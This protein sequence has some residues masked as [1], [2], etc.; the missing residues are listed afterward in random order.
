MKR[1][2]LFVLTIFLA[3]AIFNTMQA[4]GS[5]GDLWKKVDELVKKDRAQTALAEVKV[6]YSRAKREGADAQLIRSLVYI[7]GLQEELREENG[8]AS[9]EE[10]K[11]EIA[12]AKEPARSILQ[13]MLGGLYWQYLQNNRWKFYN[14]TTTVNFD[15][16]DVSTYSLEDLHRH[17][18][19]AFLASIKN[20]SL[21]KTI[22][23][24]RYDAIITKGNA[25]ALRPTLFDLL[26]HRAL[27]YFTNGERRINQPSY[28]FVIEATEAF[29]AASSFASHRFATPDSLSPE[30]KALEIFQSLIRFHLNDAKPD[31]LIDADLKRLQYVYQHSVAADKEQQYEAALQDLIRRYPQNAETKQARYLLAS[32]YNNRATKYKPLGDTTHRYDRVKARE[33][34]AAVVRDS[35]VKN[36]GW[37]NSYNLLQAIEEPSFSF[38]VEKVNVPLLAIRSFVKFKNVGELY[39]RLIPVDETLRNRMQRGGDEEI[40]LWNLLQ[41]TSY[42][43]AWTQNL[44]LTGDFQEH[45][46]EIKIDAL[47]AGN[48]I[49]FASADPSFNKTKAQMAARSFW[50]SSISYLQQENNYFLLHRQTGQPLAN[51]K[52]I[53]F[54]S[55]YDYNVR[56]TIR[57]NLGTYSSDGNGFFSIR[58]SQSRSY[59]LD[60]S[61]GSERLIDEE[62]W[63]Y[64]NNPRQREQE[65]NLQKFFFF[66]DR[67]IYRPGQTVYFKAIIL[68]K[69]ETNSRVRANQ[70]T[71]IYLRDANYQFIDSIRLTSNEF[72]S[73]QGSFSLPA[74]TLT[75]SFQLIADKDNQNYSDYFSVEEYKRPKFSVELEKPAV[76]YTAGDMIT[77][78]GVAKAYAGNAID[79]SSISYRVV[80]QPRFPY[81]WYFSKRWMPPVQQMEIAHGEATTDSE[82]KF[83]IKFTAIPD[84]SID[85]SFNPLF[86]YRVEVDVTDINGETRS[87]EITVSA[88]YTAVQLALDIPQKIEADSLRS[89]GLRTLNTAGVHLPTNISLT[90]N[91][92]QPPARL[93]RERYWQQPDLFVMSKEEFLRHFPNDEYSN[94]R[95][96]TTWPKEQVASRTDSSR[97]SGLFP[98]NRKLAPGYYEIA[99]STKDK[100]GRIVKDA[101]IVEV[102]EEGTKGLA[103]PEYLWSSGSKTIEPGEKTSIGIGSSAKNVYLIEQLDRKADPSGQRPGAIGS[104][105]EE[106]GKFRYYKLD[107]EKKVF[108]F[109]ATEADRGG[110]V[111]TYFFVKDNRVYQFTD[112]IHVPWSNKELEIAF[113]SFR[114]KTLPGSEEKWTVKISGK[115]GEKIA[116]EML[117]SMYDA[118]LDQFQPHAWNKPPIWNENFPLI[119]WQGRSNFTSVVSDRSYLQKRSVNAE[120]RY[121]EMELSLNQ[122]LVRE[123]SMNLD[124]RGTPVGRAA[125]VTVQAANAPS[126]KR[127]EE[128]QRADANADGVTDQM[129]TTSYSTGVDNTDASVTIRKNFNETAFFFPQL[130]TAEDGSISFSLTT[131]EALT[132]WK[133][134]TFAHTKELAFGL[135]TKEL[136]TQKELMI[137]PNLPRF[138]RQ[139]DHME[140]QA[141]L[142]NITDKEMTGQVSLQLFDASNNTPV[143]GWFMNTFP[144]QYFTVA[145]NSSE[146]VRFPV[147]VPFQ[148]NG[149]LGCRIIGKAGATSDGEENMLPVLSNQLLVTESMTLPVKMNES[150]DFVFQKLLA[151]GGSSTLQQRSLTVEYT[152]NPAWYAVQALPY[153]MEYPYDCAEQTWNRY[154][155]NALA[156]K[157]ANASPRIRAIFEKWKSTDTA[158]LLSNLQKNEELKSVLLEET[159]WVLDAKS[160][161]EQ[162]KNIA[163]LFDL[164]QLASKLDASLAKLKQAQN[165]NGSFAWFKGGPD[166]RYITQYILTG[167]GHLKQ[168]GVDVSKLD[169]LVNKSLAYLD[170]RMLDDYLRAKKAGITKKPAG[171]NTMGVQY[172][173]MRSFFTKQPLKPNMTEAYNYK[174]SA[175]ASGWAQQNPQLKSMTALALHRGRLTG[176]TAADTRAVQAILLSLKETSIL[177]EE[178]GRYFKD[179]VFGRSWFWHM[180]PI[181][182]QALLIEAFTEAGKDLKTADELRT[183]LIKNKQ[184]NRWNTTKATADACYAMLLRG[185][186]W[187]AEAPAVTIQLGNMRIQPAST[188]AGTG[189]FKQVIDAAS[190]RP[191]MGNIKVSVKPAGN[192]PSTTLPTWGAV[193]W[194]YFEDMDKISAAATPLVLKRKLFVEKKTDRG[195]VLEPL[196]DGAALKIGDKVKVRIELRVDRDMEYVHMKDLRAA[197]LEPMDVLSSYHWQDGLGYYQSTR[198]ASTNFF[199]SYLPKGSY[200]FE[201]AMFATQKGSFNN[202]ITTIQCMYAPEFNAHSEGLKIEVEEK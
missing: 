41:K 178:Q 152:S 137:Q 114:D 53:V 138:L 145:A 3:T 173:Y 96:E 194:Q 60:I 56:K 142:V 51:A 57:K 136:I 1:K 24:S 66:T 174:A 105:I 108:P 30:H 124:M 23:V 202:G 74:S 48:Y 26:A 10:I 46:V 166:D 150:R 19:A 117:A 35:A 107:E 88:G 132:K 167:I 99:V 176:K 28:S 43:R 72:G 186:D 87:G 39:L 4:Q 91:K 73:V 134:Q 143:D 164:V 45:S 100:S 89:I 156:S 106:A 175:A 22:P 16:K 115:K 61:Y 78:T 54:S 85:S 71:T 79:G 11:K 32:F 193:Y 21:L 154:Y 29:A 147:Q 65:K 13:S 9:I 157:I 37:A 129:D 17:I 111:A 69:G 195:P 59:G 172:I 55:G 153:L 197:A 75:G 199:F 181:E 182:T 171:V 95:D 141:K 6:I 122:G 201:Y 102:Y 169:E 83:Q 200:V 133:L 86:D 196:Q 191:E 185:T 198:D 25:R 155:A 7:T 123:E 101:R 5:Y 31:A 104:V 161:T 140:I 158:A 62:Q 33:I 149:A 20:E 38:E 52:T 12:S 119:A 40:D 82:G 68:E 127:G 159:P 14:R 168:L 84:R 15:D 113:S 44:P 8:V 50:V 77:V 189:Y 47:P 76:A 118:S 2:L 49:L 190:V 144:N 116:A 151:S 160:E 34:L 90:I 128:L 180:A 179:Q 148:F 139:G 187:L 135:N 97:V 165:E 36:V 109:T 192:A 27:D 131:P 93:I 162:R 163:L 70:T 110:F 98:L 67:S 120:R 58:D 81:P 126:Y 146:V 64:Y 92:L 125:A 170:A 112:R 103:K 177:S 94:E 18:T 42:L 80:R 121:D 188:E 130:R 183:W 184:T 63:Y